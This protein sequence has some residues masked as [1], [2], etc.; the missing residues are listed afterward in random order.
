MW[1]RCEEQGQSSKHLKAD[2]QL[3][4]A[5]CKVGDFLEILKL[6]FIVAEGRDC[7]MHR[8]WCQIHHPETPVCT[9]LDRYPFQTNSSLP[10]KPLGSLG[11]HGWDPSSLSST[12]GKTA[13][14]PFH[15]GVF[16]SSYTNKENSETAQQALLPLP[17][18]SWGVRNR[19]CSKMSVDVRSTQGSIDTCSCDGVNTLSKSTNAQAASM[20]WMN[21]WEE[22]VLIFAGEPLEVSARFGEALLN[23]KTQIVSCKHQN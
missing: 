23:F 5:L 17:Y 20:L 3:C 15:L 21:A 12:P 1:V 11:K 13:C 18:S 7:A 9:W 2:E 22:K 19:H 8:A 10:D 14:W 6:M 4:T 16:E